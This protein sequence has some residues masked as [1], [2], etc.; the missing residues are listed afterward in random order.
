MTAIRPETPDG[1]PLVFLSATRADNEWRQGLRKMMERYADYFEWWDDSRIGPG[2]N[3]KDQI[4]AAIQRA[5]VAVV[6]LSQDYLSSETATSELLHLGELA[7]AGR[8]RL[9]PIL[10]QPCEWRQFQFLRKVQ[11]WNSATPIGDVSEEAAGLELEKIAAS[12]QELFVSTSP[13]SGAGSEELHFSATANEVL[14]HAWSLAK[15]SNRG[16]I[17]S[18]CLL[19]ALADTPKEGVATTTTLHFVRKA[20]NENRNYEPEFQRFLKEGGPSDQTVV[21]VSGIPWRMT[22]NA[23]ALIRYAFDIAANVSGTWEVHTRHLLAAVIAPRYQGSHSLRERLNELGVDQHKLCAE[24]RILVSVIAPQENASEWDTILGITHPLQSPPDPDDLDVVQQG[25]PAKDIPSF[26]PYFSSYLTDSVPYGKRDGEPLDDSLG[27]RTYA[28]HLAQLIAAKDTAMPLAIGLFGAWGAGKSHFMDLLD[29]QLNRIAAQPG[30]TFHKHIVPVRFNA[31]HYLDTNLWANLVSEIFDQLFNSLQIA[32]DE[33]KQKLEN[34]K[35]RLAEQSALAAEA[36]VALTKAENVRRDAERELRRAMR[37]RV[38][39]ENRLRTMLDDLQSLLADSKT[40]T[41]KQIRAQLK[42]VAEGLG[43]PKV[44][45][46]YKEL[47]A[48]AQELQSLTGRTRALALAIFTGRGWWKRAILLGAALAAPLLISGFA[49]YGAEWMQ[50]LLAGAT[51]TVAQVVAAIGA[52]SAWLASQL[53]TGNALVGKLESAYD[54][55]TKVRTRREAEDDAAKAQVALALKKQ[56]EEQARHKLAEA[57][58]KLNTIRVELADMA[59]GRQLI[60]FLRQRATAEDYRRHLGLVSLVRSDFKQLSDLL[61]GA[62]KDTE[63][64][65][66]IDRIVLYI[67]DLDRCRSDRVIEVLEAVQL[68]LAFPLFAVVVA[69]DPRWLRQS[70]LDHYPRLLG[71]AESKQ[72]DARTSLGRPATPQDYLEKIFQ[73]PFNLQPLDKP[74]YELLVNRFFSVNGSGASTN[75]SGAKDPQGLLKKFDA[76]LEKSEVFVAAPQIS[77]GE[78]RADVSQTGTQKIEP[79]APPPQGIQV[80]PAQNVTPSVPADPQPRVDPERLVLTK[81]EI[82]DVQRFYV[83]FQT[84]RAVKR[85]ANTYSLIRVG[86]NEQEWS[87]YLGFNNPSPAYRVPLLLLAVG[88]AFPSLAR[89]WLLWLRAT[90]PAR[91]QLEDKDLDSLATSNSDTT[92]RAD[93]EKLHRCLK[94]VDLK[95]WPPP[96]PKMLETWV[97]RV[98]RYSF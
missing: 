46:S 3:W 84:P 1:K 17:T 35:N 81:G 29:E 22:Q 23:A 6:F 10:L 31:W 67:D 25:V 87:D 16:R 55:V 43:L 83:L 59:P 60:R 73:V 77:V 30:N 40:E 37:K 18:S 86:V 76:S 12:I 47:E 56:E 57:K 91:W 88:S 71:A 50:N 72:A 27:V 61:T 62:A 49:V 44:Q 97:P 70:L 96:D 53:K 11:I 42:E 79:H 45:S 39:E 14:A 26:K 95:G 92:D 41:G 65:P 78:Q 58:E 68:L 69:V 38:K 74:G 4:E 33:E 36:K 2:E 94:T 8:L 7:E 98:A 21:S 5:S 64:L 19:F 80:P 85:L 51:R 9:F 93:W 52:V 66:E 13:P 54:E 90:P 24:F 32:K 28:S 89:P 82:D 63:N 20:L 75:G 15:Q 48:R 34:L